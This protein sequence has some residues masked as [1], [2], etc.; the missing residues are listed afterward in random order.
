M[1][2]D[3]LRLRLI[4]Q[5]GFSVQVENRP[6]DEAVRPGSNFYWPA[7]RFTLCGDL[8]LDEERIR[9]GSVNCFP[10]TGKPTTFAAQV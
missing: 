2:K 4:D 9:Q 8:A 7:A 1:G 3:T 6:R 5:A 10:T